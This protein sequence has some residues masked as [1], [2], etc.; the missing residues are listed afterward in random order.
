MCIDRMTENEC[1]QEIESMKKKP[2]LSRRDFMFKGAAAL[3]AAVVF[4][5]V[6]PSTVFGANAPSS[7]G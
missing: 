6:V 7:R 2:S 5:R 3:G 4:P 1:R